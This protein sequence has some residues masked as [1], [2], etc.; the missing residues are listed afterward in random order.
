MT[1]FI[2]SGTFIVVVAFTLVSTRTGFEKAESTNSGALPRLT[3]PKAT[4]DTLVQDIGEVQQGLR[5][6]R[7]FELSNTGGETLV[8]RTIDS[9][10][11]CMAGLA[12]TNVIQ[13]G[14]RTT[15]TVQLET[16]LFEGYV[17]RSIAVSTNDPSAPSRELSLKA[18]VVP[19]F[20][21]SVPMI[22]LGEIGPGSVGEK[23]VVV[24]ATR[25]GP[26]IQDVSSADDR[27][28]IV[29]KREI[30]QT[31]QILEFRVGLARTATPG[32]TIRTNISLHAIDS[33]IGDRRL[34]IRAVVRTLVMPSNLFD[35]PVSARR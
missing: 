7:R 29:S 20:K 12:G 14:S 30:R 5:V 26:K 33:M 2:V 1:R 24:T 27:V 18:I 19:D 4:F 13:P 9:G 35:R 16:A 28:V 23:P 25:A 10:C 17:N 22:D 34:P 8:V 11:A 15:L 6:E 3:G 31:P 32:S 21:F